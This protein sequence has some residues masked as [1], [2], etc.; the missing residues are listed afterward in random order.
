VSNNTHLM[1]TSVDPTPVGLEGFRQIGS[2]VVVC[3]QLI[4]IVY[5][6]ST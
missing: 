6:Y 1:S 4:V 3:E 5:V 2:F